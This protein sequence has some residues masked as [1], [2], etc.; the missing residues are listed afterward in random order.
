MNNTTPAPLDDAAS[1]LSLAMDHH[2]HGRVQEA[3]QAYQQALALAPEDAQALHMCGM[4]HGQFGSRTQA[5]ALIGRAIELQPEHANFHN[6]LGN[7][8]QEDGQLAA[9]EASYRRAAQLD[10]A[11]TDARNNLAVLLARQGDDTQ[12]E[13]LYLQLLDDAPG[14]SDARE[15]LANL[16][17]R[18]GKL[19]EALAQ[20]AAGL[21]T[22]PR[23]RSLRRLVAR[24]YAEWGMTEQAAQVYREW[25][26]D[27]PDDP[28]PAHYLAALTGQDVPDKASAGYVA[29][30]F[31]D[32]ASSFD[33]RL[34]EL[35]YCAP[36][37]V[38]QALAARLGPPQARWRIV[39]AGCGTGLCAPLLVPYASQLVGVDLS[40]GMLV[41]A[42]QRGGYTELVQGELV[43]FLRERPDSADVIIS[44]DTLCYFGALQEFA[45]AAHASLVQGGWLIF[46]VEAHPDE[47][48]APD[49]RLQ[50]HGRYSHRA[51]YLH[52][53]LVEAGFDAPELASAT[54]RLELNKPVAGWV[55]RT[56]RV[57][58]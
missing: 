8:L 47:A 14:F 32:F 2:Q 54:L 4:L 3:A 26:R 17:L 39:D 24:A 31:D 9:A 56:Q 28:K 52:H 41:R 10:P 44:A 15:N 11:H 29:R 22:T 55:V 43:A 40:H 37:L 58:S 23:N 12:A 20:C 34:A 57:A 45:T 49:Y 30:T 1:A 21:I 42:G 19:T 48:Q 38:A 35:H 25:M 5:V 16:Y 33:G 13:Q 36:A 7:V 51:S 53:V 50:L 27:D 18:Q 6:N 46:T